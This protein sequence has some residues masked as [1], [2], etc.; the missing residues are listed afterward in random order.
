MENKMER[1]YLK[2]S[3]FYWGI[4]L[5]LTINILIIHH[6]TQDL[7]YFI[8]SILVFILTLFI[9]YNKKIKNKADYKLNNG[10]KK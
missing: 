3:E 2:P 5:L 6:I 7:S 9:G 4:G 1:K 8:L 10:G